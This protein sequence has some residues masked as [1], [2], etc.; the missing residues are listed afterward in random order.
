MASSNVSSGNT[1]MRT[2]GRHLRRG[3]VLTTICLLLLSNS[4]CTLTGG[5]VS[6]LWTYM[7]FFKTLPA[8][9]VPA[10]QSQLI[11]DKLHEDERYNRVPVLD[12]VE[13]DVFCVDPPSE[14][15]VMRAMPND[16]AGGFAFF[17]E[18]QINNVRIVVEPLVDRLDDCKVYPLVGPARLHHCHYKCTI[19]YDKTVRA[20][21]PVPF[22]HTDQSQEVVYIDK[23]HL[24]RCA[25]PA[26]Q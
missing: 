16:P 18:T 22:T 12:P 26:M 2:F 7:R 3:V 14:D 8:V 24:I 4:G 25:G 21:W 15:Q 23:D 9:P 1:T 17:Q 13:G 19:Y 20:Y 10:Y 6:V 5:F 11:E